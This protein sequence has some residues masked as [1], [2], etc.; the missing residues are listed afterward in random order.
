MPVVQG[1]SIPG[2][3]PVSNT[4]WL[5]AADASKHAVKGSTRCRHIVQCGLVS[6]KYTTELGLKG[7]CYK[8]E[9][10]LGGKPCA[11]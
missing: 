5:C 9:Q 4:Y 3:L 8:E 2:Y 11:M 10:G 6:N 7:G 1:Y